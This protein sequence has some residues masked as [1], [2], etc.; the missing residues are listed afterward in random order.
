M[1]QNVD[2]YKKMLQYISPYQRSYKNT[3]ISLRSL[4]LDI[5]IANHFTTLT[6]DQD[7]FN[8]GSEPLECEYTFN[9]LKKSVV[10]AL[11]IVLPDGSV[12]NS[13]IE[14][15]QKALET[16]QDSSSQG[17]AAA[18]G[19]SKNPDTLMVH[20]GNILPSESVKIRIVLACPT[21]AELNSWNFVVPSEFM[22]NLLDVNNQAYPIEVRIR[23][24]SIGAIS[25]YRSTWNLSWHLSE[26]K[27]NLTGFAVLES[28]LKEPLSI[29]YI[30]SNTYTP[31]CIIQRKGDKYAAMISFIPQNTDGKDPEYLESTGEYIF[32][33]DRSWSMAGNRLKIAKMQLF[34]F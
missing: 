16:Y 6:V 10:V 30:N 2:R 33:L 21:S 32:I 9:I 14:D 5:N 22:P 15:E 34:S 18:L 4:K 1:F 3:S 24:L 17:Y 7:F 29:T 19:R 23:I 11:N 20:V 12:L 26:D 25:D 28:I 27:L 13:R 8:S 31:T